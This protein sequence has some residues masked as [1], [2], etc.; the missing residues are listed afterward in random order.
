MAAIA[1]MTI[2]NDVWAID[3]AWI[4]ASVRTWASG[5]LWFTDHTACFSS[6]RKSA[7][8]ARDDRTT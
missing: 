1:S 6:L 2:A 7:L 5:T 8:P 3:A 4:S